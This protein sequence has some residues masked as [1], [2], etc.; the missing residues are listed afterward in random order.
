M[1]EKGL[2]AMLKTH[3][4]RYIYTCRLY[5]DLIDGFDLEEFRGMISDDS[6]L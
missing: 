6:N 3:P 5:C 4:T 2:I 1:V